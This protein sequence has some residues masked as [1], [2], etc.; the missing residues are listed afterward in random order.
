VTERWN[1]DVIESAFVPDTFTD[2]CASIDIIGPNARLTF[3]VPR[4]RATP[5]GERVLDERHIVARLVIPIDQLD[6]IARM[7]SDR[8]RMAKIEHIAP[9]DFPRLAN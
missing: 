3:V 1:T 6:R 5:A 9:D 8:G 7:I 2:E 4:F